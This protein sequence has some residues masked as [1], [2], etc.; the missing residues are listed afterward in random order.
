MKR[1]LRILTLLSVALLTAGHTWANGDIKVKSTV[2]GSVA[3]YSNAEC[4]A[5]TVITQAA[6]GATVY[7]KVTP[8]FGYTIYE[9]LTKGSITVEMSTGSGAAQARTAAPVIPE[10]IPVDYVDETAGIYSFTMPDD[11]EFGYIYNVS[12]SVTFPE[13]AYLTGVEYVDV[14][15]TATTTA[16]GVK[17]YVLDGTEKTL[18]RDGTDTN[19]N[20]YETWYVC[21]SD[22]AYT[23]TL[24]LYGNVNTI[25]ADY[26]TL[27]VGTADSRISG[28]GIT[29]TTATKDICFFGQTNATGMIFV[30]SEKNGIYDDGGSI[31]ITYCDVNVTTSGDYGIRG[32]AI[33]ILGHADGSNTVEVNCSEYGI[34]GGSVNIKYC[35]TNVV[36]NDENDGASKAIHGSDITFEGIANGNTVNTLTIQTNHYGIV[37]DYGGTLSIINSN[38]DITSG[39]KSIDVS[40]GDLTITGCADGSNTLAVSSATTLEAIYCKNLTV[41]NCDFEIINTAGKGLYASED[42][43]I[44]GRADGNNTLTIQSGGNAIDIGG[45]FTISDCKLDIEADGRGIEADGGV[46]ITGLDDDKHP[47]NIQCGDHGICGGD[48]NITGL[49]D[50]KSTVKVNCSRGYGIYGNSVTINYCDVNVTISGNYGIRGKAINILGHADGSNTVKVN[51]S[52][53]GIIGGSGGSVNIK[54]CSTNVVCKD[55]NDGVTQAIYGSDITFEGIANGNTVNTLTIQTNHYGIVTDDGGT[56]SISNSNIDITTGPRSIDAGGN[57]TITGRANGSNTLTVRSA[58]ATLPTI[59]CSNLT[60]SNCD[61]EIINTAGG[62]ELYAKGAINITGCADGSNTLTVS[63][64]CTIATIESNST[65]SISNCKAEITNTSSGRAIWAG[66]VTIDGGEVKVTAQE[67]YDGIYTSSNITLGWRKPGD[68]IQVSSYNC[69]NGTMKTAANSEMGEETHRNRFE[70]FSVSGTG[71]ESDPFVETPFAYIEGNYTFTA[72]QLTSLAGKKLVAAPEPVK[73]LVWDDTEE[74]LVETNITDD[75]NTANEFLPVLTGSHGATTLATA[76]TD[77]DHKA[78]AWYLVEDYTNGTD[79]N[80]TG[81]LTLADYCHVHLIL[82]DDAEMMVDAGSSLGI[83]GDTEAS[84]TIYGQG[85]T[86]EGLLLTTSADNAG[87]R[88]DGSLTISGGSLTA[89]GG[90]NAFGIYA[91]REIDIRG[92]QIET[93]GDSGIWSNDETVNIR[94][95]KVTATGA[96]NDHG[97]GIRGRNGVEISGGQVEATGGYG[98]GSYTSGTVENETT[99]TL[100]WTAASDYIKASSYRGI[101]KTADGQRFVVYNAETGT[102]ASGIISGT[103]GTDFTADGIADKVLRPLDGNYVATTNGQAGFLGYNRAFDLTDAGTTTHYYIYKPGDQVQFEYGNGDDEQ[104]EVSG[105]DGVLY[106]ATIHANTFT[107]PSE[108]VTLTLRLYLTDVAYRDWDGTKLVDETTDANI[109]VYTLQSLLNG[110]NITLG[111]AGETSWYVFN[112]TK[113][114][115]Y[116]GSITL[117]GDVHL[118]FNGETCMHLNPLPTTEEYGINMQGH[119]LFIHGQSEAAGGGEFCVPSYER[120]AT[121][122]FSETGGNVTINGCSVRIYSTT[123][124]KAVNGIKVGGDV[125]INGSDVKIYVETGYGIYAQNVTLN[126]SVVSAESNDLSDIYATGDVTINGG[127]LISFS[128]GSVQANNIAINGGQINTYSFN[129]TNDI[130]LGWTNSSDYIN[131]INYVGTVKTKSGNR[132]VFSKFYSP[133]SSDYI[134]VI[135]GNTTLTDGQRTFVSHSGYFIPAPAD[136]PAVTYI[137]ANGETK[138]IATDENDYNNFVY[139][140]QGD[141]TTLGVDGEVSWYLAQGTKDYT[142]ALTLSGTTHIILEDEAAMTIT[143]DGKG[144]SGGHDLSLYGQGGGTA[145]LTVNSK[146]ECIELADATYKYDF[147]MNGVNVTLDNNADGAN[148]DALTC[149]DA[150]IHE[151]TLYIESNG[152]GIYCNNFTSIGAAVTSKVTQAAT[153]AIHAEDDVTITGGQVWAECD[154][155]TYDDSKGIYAGGNINLDWIHTSDNI[156]VTNYT[157]PVIIADGKAFAYKYEDA[158]EIKTSAPFSGS[159][160]T[161]AAVSELCGKTLIPSKLLPTVPAGTTATKSDFVAVVSTDGTWMFGKDNATLF[162]YK[163][164][165]ETTGELLLQAVEPNAAGEY[166]LPDGVPAIIGGTLLPGHTSETPTVD[167]IGDLSDDGAPI[168]LTGA[169]TVS[170]DPATPSEATVAEQKFAA[171]GPEPTLFIGDGTQTLED[172]LPATM[173]AQEKSDMLFF[174]PFYTVNNEGKAELTFRLTDMGPESTPPLGAM[175]LGVSKMLLLRL[176][177]NLAGGAMPARKHGIYLDLAGDETGI[178]DIELDAAAGT[179][180]WYT[181]DGRKLDGAPTQKGIYIQDGMKRVVR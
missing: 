46:T 106:D 88:I 47:M 171:A 58:S 15:G 79:A 162:A 94:G 129:A 77:A 102:A 118:I 170:A 179:G 54:Y 29:A 123:N 152:S 65:F 48:I 82:A 127:K 156:Y 1:T 81:T 21:N 116:Y 59:D 56:L 18:G 141:E 115:I 153:E 84:L 86:T 70:A 167:N 109:K 7:M 117:V 20:P 31:T 17:V 45:T 111:K 104:L 63:S 108:D 173:T 91:E 2:G 51:C 11:E 120:P 169:S 139:L 113:T 41:S 3:F 72:D 175:V 172:L 23:S 144:I 8:D 10:L 100:G 43:N 28:S 73:Y 62:K 35:S 9:I 57:V 92:G 6:A 101:V 67:G 126:G 125:N 5:T 33:N 50:G 112:N 174:V 99:M 128:S 32:K 131:N 22:Q 90:E 161:D 159:L 25:I 133:T 75:N 95:G 103:M 157:S 178:R 121:G 151:G 145:S 19:D 114:L 138:D 39:G 40:N 12:V 132:F 176:I 134:A 85:G 177:Q 93:T 97:Y 122:F 37:T 80:Y 74:K 52:E 146:G 38:I 61:F 68:Y 142:S 4:T 143:S 158:G 27:S 71:T 98:I 78:E 164:L 76:G 136:F 165:D 119:N 110:S 155:V 83:F 60:V 49:A 36:C 105:L 87:I 160:T 181:L 55:E 53:Y 30:N 66:S 135:E 64:A 149:E 147:A 13:K 34:I 69:Y 137:D 154:D 24:T 14:T 44:T 89:T 130:T 140:L 163:G 168:G 124:Y 16:E 96:C 150:D 107:M 148:G 180:A 26:Q 42:I 166:G